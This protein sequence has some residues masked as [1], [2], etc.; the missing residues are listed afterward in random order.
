[1]ESIGEKILRLKK[2]KNAVIM[3]HNYTMP[4]V[5][6][7]SDYVGDSLGLSHAASKTDADVIV[8]CGVSFMGETA[9]IL[10]PDKKVLLPE[11]SAGCSMAS[12]CT[13]S[14]IRELKKAHP[15]AA[16]VAY[17]NTTADAKAEADI[18]CTSSNSVEV[19]S[20]L[21][22]KEVLFVPDANL[23]DY[24]ARHISGKKIIP[25]R[26]YCSVHHGITVW[27]IKDLLSAYP[28]SKIISHPECRAEVLDISDFVSSTEKMIDYVKNSSGSRFIVATDSNMAHRIKKERKDAELFFPPNPVC[29]TMRM[30]DSRSVLKT[31]EEEKHEVVLDH[32]IVEKARRPV[33]RMLS[34]R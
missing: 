24:T 4:D 11:P 31:L 30:F 3:A 22:E 8:F 17:V 5:Q 20:S 13:G 15:G 1:M 9:K 26:G 12:M 10:N 29:H 16:V 21:E 7:I 28:D 33:E 23:A 6:D 18:C 32:T 2:E 34:V 25:F 14:Q 27:Q 19:V